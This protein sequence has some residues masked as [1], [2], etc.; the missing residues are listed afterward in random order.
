MTTRKH[1]PWPELPPEVGRYVADQMARDWATLAKP[2]REVCKDCPADR[3]GDDSPCQSC[4][5][6][7]LST[8]AAIVTL[9]SQILRAKDNHNI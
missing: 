6:C 5:F 9:S 1:N 4:P 2:C 3:D 8:L 7:G